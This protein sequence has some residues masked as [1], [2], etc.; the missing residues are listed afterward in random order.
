MTAPIAT[1]NVPIFTLGQ[2]GLQMATAVQG[3]PA[4]VMPQGGMGMQAFTMP[5]GAQQY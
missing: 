5:Q 4:F 2:G 3:A 1:A